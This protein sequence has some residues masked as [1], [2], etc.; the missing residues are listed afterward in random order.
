MGTIAPIAPSFA[1]D[2]D[3][4]G[5]RKLADNFFDVYPGNELKKMADALRY[6]VATFEKL[7][8]S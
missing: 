5:D 4:D 6:L 3:L 7:I 2:G 1:A 8:L